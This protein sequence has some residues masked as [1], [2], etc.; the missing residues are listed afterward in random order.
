MCLGI[1]VGSQLAL[2]L[3]AYL[4][5][6]VGGGVDSVD[7]RHVARHGVLIGGE[8]RGRTIGI[9]ATQAAHTDD[10]GRLAVG[11]PSGQYKCRE[12]KAARSL[13]GRE[14]DRLALIVL[15]VA[16][17]HLDAIALVVVDAIAAVGLQR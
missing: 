1:A 6:R 8:L 4:H 16:V 12:S 11:S 17:V 10:D 9:V 13:L 14:A 2:C 3:V 15:Q 5:V 7:G